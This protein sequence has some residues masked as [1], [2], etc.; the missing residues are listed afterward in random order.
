[1]LTGD[2]PSPIDPPSGCRFRTRCWKAQDKSAHEEPALIDRGPGHPVACH[3]PEPTWRRRRGHRCNRL[4]LGDA[5]RPRHGA[6]DIRP[7]VAGSTIE[8]GDGIWS[9]EGLAN[10]YLVVTHVGRVVVNAGGPEEGAVHQQNFDEVS[11]APLRLL[12]PLTGEVAHVG[13]AAAFADAASTVA[14]V[15]SP[16]VDAHH[17]EGQTSLTV[18]EHRFD[19]HATPGERPPTRCSSGSPIRPPPSSAR[20]SASSWAACPTSRPWAAAGPATWTPSSTPLTW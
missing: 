12:L 17:F 11:D 7:A 13:G 2:V 20:S 18:G 4:V 8:V 14:P 15:G 5:T 19:L 3:F 1:M 9:S 6:A 16:V 10:S